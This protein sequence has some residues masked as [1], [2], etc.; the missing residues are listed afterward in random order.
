VEWPA[1]RLVKLGNH[2]L[3]GGEQVV[4]DDGRHDLPHPVPPGATVEADLRVSAPA[5]PGRYE[6]EFDLVQEF[7]AWWAD[8]GNPTV[9]HPILVTPPEPSTPPPDDRHAE[10]GAPAG[11][12]VG[13]SV[14]PVGD[15]VIEIHPVRQ[16]LVRSLLEHA[17]CRILHVQPDG[18]AGPGWL[19]Y[20]YVATVV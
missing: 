9:R 18:L 2:W 11:R 3:A 14:R 20:T 1:G 12:P 4:R 5:R 16:D 19:S 15:S 6:L 17:G 13:D 7:V 10:P 8:N